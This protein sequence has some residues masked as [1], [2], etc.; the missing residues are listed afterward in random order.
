MKI[1]QSEGNIEKLLPLSVLINELPWGETKTRGMIQRGELPFLIK[2]GRSY[3]FYKSSYE[4]Y[5]KNME[6]KEI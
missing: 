5:F 6:G 2:I 3:F 1:N 4:K